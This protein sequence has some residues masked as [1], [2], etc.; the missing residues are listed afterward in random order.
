MF[1]SHY[2][3]HL[4]LHFTYCARTYKIIIIISLSPPFL[5]PSQVSTVWRTISEAPKLIPLLFDSRRGR[6][7]C[8]VYLLFLKC[9]YVGER[10]S[11]R[12]RLQKSCT[13]C[14]QKHLRQLHILWSR[15]NIVFILRNSPDYISFIFHLSLSLSL[16]LSLCLPHSVQ[17]WNLYF[18]G[19]ISLILLLLTVDTEEDV[20]SLRE[21]FFILLM[22]RV[23]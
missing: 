17:F 4:S 1:S 6:R 14:V 8:S 12:T 3:S 7:Y 9:I 5:A 18:R 16:S 11:S 15:P 22:V 23:E 20:K 13:L 2:I 21:W 19:V 10:E